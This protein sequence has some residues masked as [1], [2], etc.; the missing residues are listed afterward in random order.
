MLL[1][2]LENI[3][4]TILKKYNKKLKAKVKATTAHAD[5][6]ISPRKAHLVEAHL[7]KSQ[8]RR[9]PRSFASAA[10]PTVAPTRCIT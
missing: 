2:D 3:K 6:K 5:G 9:V 7:I 8:R 4:H 1:P 10:R